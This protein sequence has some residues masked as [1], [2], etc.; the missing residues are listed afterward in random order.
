MKQEV[1]FK[2]EQINKSDFSKKKK[3]STEEAQERERE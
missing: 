2:R 3:E 1:F